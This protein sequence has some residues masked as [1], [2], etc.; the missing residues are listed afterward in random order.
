MQPS[1][2]SSASPPPPAP[3]GR[4]QSRSMEP[5]EPREPR[6][7]GPG[8]ET[9]AAPRWEEAKTFYDNLAPKKKPKSPKPQNAVTIAVSSRALFRMDEEQRIYTEQG[10]EE[11]VRYQL[12]HENEPF[13]PGPAFPFV[14]ALEAVNRRLR[15]L[16]P[17]SE[18]LFDIVLMTNNHAQVGVRLINSINHYDLFIERFC[19]TGGN[20]PIC[21]LKAYHTNLYL[22]ADAEK[23]QEAIDEGL[24]QG[25]VRNPWQGSSG[26][27]DP[28]FQP[29]FQ[30]DVRL[31][32][33]SMTLLGIAAAT[34]FSPS[35]DMAVSQSQLR[36]AFDG[37]AVL[38]S[39][40]SERIVKAH[41]LDRFFEHEKAHENKPLA[42][43]PLKGFL[44][45]LGRLQKKFYSKGLRLECPIRTYLVTARSAASSGARALK[46]LRSWGLETDEALFL[47]GAPK[48]PLLEKIR[49]HIFFD[50][51]M[52]HVA[53][54]QEMGTVAAHVPY[55]VAQTPR[56]T[57]PTKQ[58]PS[59]Q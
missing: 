27:G 31:V 28:S 36:V 18:D 41:G 15:E 20:S 38:F 1:P 3:A 2:A 35:K 16:Y 22:S 44:E 12:E 19:M 30:T 13:N 7:L 40:E 54:A 6:E 51:Q 49:P 37:D 55:G 57:A 42:Q 25:P 10:V 56:R 9:A 52:F 34:I 39:D 26:L 32:H 53:G 58:T 11:Y 8:A 24:Y 17:D 23:V 43:G 59:A 50:D 46:T 33:T 21:Y 48:G 14:K 47:A 4:G 45:A 5:G 29:S